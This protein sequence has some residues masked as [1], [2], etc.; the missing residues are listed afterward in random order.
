MELKK[1]FE[2]SYI[3]QLAS[4]TG[5]GAPTAL[6]AVVITK[7]DLP[8][9]EASSLIH[10]ALVKEGAAK[11]EIKITSITERAGKIVIL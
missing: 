5:A 7:P 3:S 6:S 9:H 8:L 10:D 1:M 4:A 2:V 11:H